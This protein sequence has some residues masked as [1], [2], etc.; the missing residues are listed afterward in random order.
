MRRVPHFEATEALF[1]RAL[2]AGLDGAAD[3]EA[4]RPAG[5]WRAL[6]LNRLEGLD[7]HAQVPPPLLALSPDA[8]VDVAEPEP[9]D[10]PPSP[11]DLEVAL[12]EAVDLPDDWTMAAALAGGTNVAHCLRELLRALD[13][14]G[15]PRQVAEVLPALNT[16]LDAG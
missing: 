15:Q 16:P 4:V 12:S 14:N 11:Q 2:S 5:P 8:A 13:W 6:R 7:P 10:V 3:A 1:T 9:E